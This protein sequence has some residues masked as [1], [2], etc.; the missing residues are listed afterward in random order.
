MSVK[1]QISAQKAVKTLGKATKS[2]WHKAHEKLWTQNAQKHQHILNLLFQEQENEIRRECEIMR[3]EEGKE[4][5][6]RKRVIFRERGEAADRIMRIL[7]DYGLVSGGDAGMYLAETL[8]TLHNHVAH[9][10]R[11]VKRNKRLA[12]RS[13][14]GIFKSTTTGSGSRDDVSVS[15]TMS[16][17]SDA[18]TFKTHSTTTVA[19]SATGFIT[20]DSLDAALERDSMFGGRSTS[21]PKK[22]DAKTKTSNVTFAS[23]FTGT[24]SSPK[25][26]SS[27]APVSAF[28][29]ADTMLDYSAADTFS[30]ATNK[31]MVPDAYVPLRSPFQK[32][33]PRPANLDSD[34]ENIRQ[35]ARTP[36]VVLPEVEKKRRRRYRS[37]MVASPEG[38]TQ[39]NT[40]Q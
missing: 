4:D 3:L 21:S 31:E 27:S 6:Q 25:R 34:L 15:D 40:I 30:S 16:T 36:V 37:R 14:R 8:K 38:T 10:D 26:T 11:N 1:D 23:D 24:A 29:T 2:N 17:V 39:G 12:D 5:R 33:K 22:R 7:H 35:R 20:A 18:T 28:P 13:R 9:P 19:N 32:L